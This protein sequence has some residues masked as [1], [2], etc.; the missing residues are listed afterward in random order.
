[1]SDIRLSNITKSFG[2]AEVLRGIDIDIK[3]GEFVVFC[4]PVGLR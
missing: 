1:M 2:T 3:N 4:R